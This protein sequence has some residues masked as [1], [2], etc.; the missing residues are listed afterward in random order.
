MKN[1][2][3]ICLF[4]FSIA[5]TSINKSPKLIDCPSVFFASEHRNYISSDNEE[6]TLE[7]LAYKANIN[8]YNFN[9]SCFQQNNIVTYPLEVL[10]V[11]YPLEKSNEN[12]S[13]P[14]YVALLDSFD[15][16]IEIQYFSVTGKFLTDSDTKQYIE[17]DLPESIKIIT[18]STKPVST[19]ILG[20]ML[21]NKKERLIN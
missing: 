2:L 19:L 3:F 10:F 6:I 7:N 16:L 5:C 21:N 17:T 20:F 4:F 14:V 15:N 13:L 12:I 9:N 18:S 1:I 11:V 8:N